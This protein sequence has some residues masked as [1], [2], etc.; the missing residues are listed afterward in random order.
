MRT[1]VALDD[2]VAVVIDEPRR[3]G[4]RALREVINEV[5]RIGLARVDRRDALGPPVRT[6]IV[7]LGACRLPDVDDVPDV[8]AI[9]EGEAYR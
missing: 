6:R 9:A 8:L 5:L 1:T 4:R 7:S 2:D 3:S